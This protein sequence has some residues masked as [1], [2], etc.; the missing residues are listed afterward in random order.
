MFVKDA[1]QLINRQVAFLAMTDEAIQS[2]VFGA[3]DDRVT[4]AG[5]TSITLMLSQGGKCGSGEGENRKR[6]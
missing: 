1:I 3:N 4:V 6:F 5:C 2:T